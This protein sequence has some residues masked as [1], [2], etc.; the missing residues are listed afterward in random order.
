MDVPNTETNSTTT[1][2][3]VLWPKT[4]RKNIVPILCI[5]FVVFFT[6]FEILNRFSHDSNKSLSDDTQNKK[7]HLNQLSKLIVHAMMPLTQN[8][9]MNDSHLSNKKSVF[10][11]D[12]TLLQVSK[13]PQVMP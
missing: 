13:E 6:Q 3:L 2:N 9:S 5:L 11:I 10:I 12:E 7:N 4:A 1:S 8:K